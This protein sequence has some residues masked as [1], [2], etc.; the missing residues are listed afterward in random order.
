MSTQTQTQTVAEQRAAAMRI[1]IA[2]GEM[3]Q[4]AGEIPSGHLY[5]MLM[6]TGMSL[7]SYNRVISALVKCKVVTQ[8]NYLLKWVGPGK[9]EGR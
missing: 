8:E 7:E 4:D 9:G 1:I 6:P 5:A 2:M 3:I